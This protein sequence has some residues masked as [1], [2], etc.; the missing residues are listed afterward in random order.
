M[1]NKIHFN[2]REVNDLKKKNNATSTFYNS[3][4]VKGISMRGSWKE[5]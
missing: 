2:S 5:Q 1:N 3:F 4:N